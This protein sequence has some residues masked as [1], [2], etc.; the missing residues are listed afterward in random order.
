MSKRRKILFGG[1]AACLISIAV[2][3]TAVTTQASATKSTVANGTVYQANLPC[4]QQIVLRAWPAPHAPILRTK[5]IPPGIYKVAGNAF[6]VIGRLE[7][8][9]CWLSTSNS[10]DTVSGEGGAVGNG[11]EESGT[12]AGGI[13]ANAV[14]DYT[15]VV[16]RANDHLIL[17]CV[18]KHPHQGT[19]AASATMIATKI[20]KVIDVTRH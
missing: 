2:A 8:D 14:L 9:N 20:S 15:V 19:Y 3:L 12:G 6:I 4:C 11:A 10:S 17:N 5:A 16:K 13:Y 7:N 18:S 1:A